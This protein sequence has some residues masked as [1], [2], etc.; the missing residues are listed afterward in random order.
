MT[1]L[2][3]ANKSD[4]LRTTIPAS[5]VKQLGLK[6]GDQ[7]GWN[8]VPKNNTFQVTVKIIKKGDRSHG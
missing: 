1:N 6:V 8:L 7:I 3:L 5:I 4:S 2:V